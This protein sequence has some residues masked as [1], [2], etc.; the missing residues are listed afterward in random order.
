MP[1]RVR[2]SK[3]IKNKTPQVEYAA[4]G[5]CCRRLF[6]SLNKT[7]EAARYGNRLLPKQ[8]NRQGGARV[9]NL[10]AWSFDLR[11]AGV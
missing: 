11:R 9:V 4:K 10:P 2:V 8:Y 5:Q 3:Q 7:I 1:R 6:H